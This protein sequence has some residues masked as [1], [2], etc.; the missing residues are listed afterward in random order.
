MTFFVHVAAL[1]TSR[2]P[3]AAR[4]AH[5]IT[6]RF[7]IVGEN[8]FNADTADQL[9]R[10]VAEDSHRAWTHFDKLTAP[11]GDQNEIERRIEQ[12]SRQH[13][14]NWFSCLAGGAVHVLQIAFVRIG[15]A[16]RR[17]MIRAAS[18]KTTRRWITRT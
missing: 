7:Q 4:L 12:A 13:R 1:E 11:V 17:K 6:R 18:Q 15:A 2:R 10:A 14:R 16:A 3:A 8:E 5:F 9:F